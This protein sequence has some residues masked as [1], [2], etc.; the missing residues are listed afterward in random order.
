[1]RTSVPAASS[2]LSAAGRLRF[3]PC[4]CDWMCPRALPTS[5]HAARLQYL[6]G[7]LPYQQLERVAPQASLLQRSGGAGAA[8]E[9][10]AS[11]DMCASCREPKAPEAGAER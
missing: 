6:C 5:M 4:C 10:A 2:A 1:M 3:G 11:A 9:D 8:E 7:R